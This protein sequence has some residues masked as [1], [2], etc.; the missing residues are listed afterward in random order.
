M[1]GT[2]EASQEIGDVGH[3][4]L[5]AGLGFARQALGIQAALI[6]LGCG[7]W[8]GRRLRL[9]RLGQLFAQGVERF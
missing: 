7:G 4:S 8:F 3:P 9:P 6:N 1:R 2:H 5:V